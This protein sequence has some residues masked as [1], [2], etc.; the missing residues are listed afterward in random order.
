MDYR[1]WA[2]EYREEGHIFKQLREAFGIPCETYYD[3]K[4]KFDSGYYET[5]TK[6]ERRRKIDKK[7]LKQ[8]VEDRPDA[9]LKEYAEQFGCTAVVVRQ[10]ITIGLRVGI[11][12]LK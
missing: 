10:Y 5:T 7:Q 6:R 9:V 12:T 1:K 8:A 11:M 2:V 4:E 3:W